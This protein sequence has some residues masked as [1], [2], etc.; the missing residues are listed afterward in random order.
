[1]STQKQKLQHT[2][3]EFFTTGT[4]TKITQTQQKYNIHNHKLQHT[5]QNLQHTK[6]KTNIKQQQVQTTQMILIKAK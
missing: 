1:V 5:Q 3:T 4:Q 6:T 2:Q